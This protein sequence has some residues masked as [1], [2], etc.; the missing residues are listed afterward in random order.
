[1]IGCDIGCDKAKVWEILKMMIDNK[2]KY[3]EVSGDHDNMPWIESLRQRAL[4]GL[5]CD[6]WAHLAQRG[7]HDQERQ[8]E[9]AQQDPHFM[10]SWL[11]K[12]LLPLRTTTQSETIGRKQV[13]IG[14][15]AGCSQKR[16]IVLTMVY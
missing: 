1:M 16:P 8:Q 7:E 11:Q 6:G 12:Y 4:S 2:E 14:F 9:L 5:P 10:V 3:L 13:P 15:I